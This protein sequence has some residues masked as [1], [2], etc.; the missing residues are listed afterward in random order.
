M[1]SRRLSL[2][3]LAGLIAV[4]NEAF[5]QATNDVIFKVPLNLTKLAADITRVKVTCTLVAPGSNL[6]FNPRNPATGEQMFPVLDGQLV[7]TAMVIVDGGSGA[8]PELVGATIG[9]ICGLS[10]FSN[11][12]QRWDQFSENQT[13]EVFRLAPTPGDIRGTFVW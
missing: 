9:Y 7:T 1:M 12:L 6:P 10:G 5:A 3:A 8:G 11:R 2:V 13:T 4:A